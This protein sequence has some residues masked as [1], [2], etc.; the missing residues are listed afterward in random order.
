MLITMGPHQFEVD[1]ETDRY[2]RDESASVKPRFWSQVASGAWETDF[3]ERYRR[4]LARDGVVIDV[5]AWIGPYALLAVA[6]GRKTIAVEPDP[7][8]LEKLLRNRAKLRDPSRLTAVCAAIWPRREWVELHAK[9]FGD[10]ETSIAARRERRGKLVT[11]TQSFFAPGAPLEDVEALINGEGI[12]LLKVDM[13]GAEYENLP[14]LLD[15]VIRHRCDFLIS[16]HPENLVGLGVDV[17]DVGARIRKFIAAIG[18]V[19][20][21]EMK[22]S[23]WQSAD[24]LA[25]I[26]DDARLGAS[27]K[28]LHVG[29]LAP[30]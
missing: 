30:V 6:A 2:S 13:E 9:E 19:A 26:E 1:P 15:L 17:A 25:A 8:A 10:S 23:E 24:A 21:V 20:K 14:S 12:S 4:S 5:G 16:F 28:A 18:N 11:V 7:N 29:W 22:I 27:L 3:V